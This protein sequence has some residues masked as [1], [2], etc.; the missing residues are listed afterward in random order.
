MCEWCI[1]KICQ[2]VFTKND[3]VAPIRTIGV[4]N[5]IKNR[6]KYY[7]KF[8]QSD[9]KTDQDNF[10][11]ARFY[12]K[13]LWIIENNLTRRN[14]PEEKVKKKKKLTRRKNVWK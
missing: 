10:K 12:L 13:K 5:P 4:L 6:D 9:K 11:N 2:Y 1:H 3:S 14:F 8:K 7:K